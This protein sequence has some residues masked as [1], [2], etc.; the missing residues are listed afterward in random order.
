MPRRAQLEGA[1]GR[2]D[3]LDAADQRRQPGARLDQ[4]ELGG[5]VQRA[6]EIRGTMT[7]GVG[8][9]Q[10]DAAN[11]F[12]FRILQGHHVVVDLDRLERLEEER[13]AAGR[14]SVH[15]ARNRMAM[16]RPDHHHVTA[17][18]IGDNLVL[19]I[20]GGIAAADQRIQRA[21]QLRPLAPQPVADSGE[22]RAGIVHDIAA[23]I[24][25]APDVGILVFERG[26]GISQRT[27]QRI[28]ARQAPDGVARGVHRVEKFR[29]PEEPQR[30]ER[31]ALDGQRLE[32]LRQLCRCEQREAGNVGERACPFGRGALAGGDARGV[33]G[34]T[35]L[36]HPLVAT[37]RDRERGSRRD[38][39]LEFEGPEC[40]RIHGYRLGRVDQNCDTRTLKCTTLLF[41][42]LRSRFSVRVQF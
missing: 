20:L 38:D 13:G 12:R 28:A 21:P 4:V 10:Q 29:Q 41:R 33:S 30:F 5:G 25:L 9:R 18:A 17:V 37:R 7:I 2:H 22:R 1:V 27:E 42:V 36:E 39:A 15:K 3:R 40:A 16:F 24:D 26:G 23:R 34:R 6:G 35:Q 8:Q 31:P 14:R 11:F 19:Q 32:R